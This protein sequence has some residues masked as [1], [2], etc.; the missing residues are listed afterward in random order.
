MFDIADMVMSLPVFTN[1]RFQQFPPKFFMEVLEWLWE[2]G[3]SSL[4]GDHL[5]MMWSDAPSFRVSLLKTQ[6]LLV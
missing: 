3:L 6:E 4:L 5:E 2:Q 1:V